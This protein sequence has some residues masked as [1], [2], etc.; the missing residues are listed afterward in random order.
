MA[1]GD[2]GAL[3]GGRGPG[4]A[5][6]G[7]LLDRRRRGAVVA[8]F[9]LAIGSWSILPMVVLTGILAIA[10]TYPW[11]RAVEGRRQAKNRLMTLIIAFAFSLALLPL[12]SLL[13]EVFTRGLHAST[14]TSSP[15]RPAAR[16]APRAGPSTRSSAR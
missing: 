2:V 13:F 9:L 1:G 15:H 8:A 14:S 5:R 12:L 4:A 10:I 6:A 3:L 11:S 7:R 16:S